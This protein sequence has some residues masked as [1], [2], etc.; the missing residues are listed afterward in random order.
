MIFA[1]VDPAVDGRELPRRDLQRVA[2]GTPAAPRMHC[3]IMST[4]MAVRRGR[5]ETS[6]RSCLRRFDSVVFSLGVT[7][8]PG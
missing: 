3:R 1:A 6:G 5:P 8:P 7:G 4:L 2:N